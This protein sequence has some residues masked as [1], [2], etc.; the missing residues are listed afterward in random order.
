MFNH[1][2]EIDFVLHGHRYT[3]IVYAANSTAAREL[4][5]ERYPSCYIVRCV[6]VG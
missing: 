1:P 4:V 2:F 5:K 3:E 6:P